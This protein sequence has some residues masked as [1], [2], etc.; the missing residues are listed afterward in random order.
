[1]LILLLPITTLCVAFLGFYVWHRQLARKRHFEIADAA[2]SASVI[3]E[4]R[5]RI[6]A[7]KVRH[8]QVSIRATTFFVDDVGQRPWSPNRFFAA[9]S[10]LRTELAKR[11]ESFP[12]KYAVKH[13]AGDPM[14][15]R[16]RTA[17]ASVAS[18]PSAE[19]RARIWAPS[20]PRGIRVGVHPVQGRLCGPA[21]RGPHSLIVGC[22]GMTASRRGSGGRSNAQKLAS[23]G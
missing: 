15:I 7:A 22:M 17:T 2:L 19:H 11:H 9:F 6:D 20:R 12:T 10:R 8:R 5:A 23:S 3:P 4:L 13:Y 1:M 14:R 21:G 16:K 18:S